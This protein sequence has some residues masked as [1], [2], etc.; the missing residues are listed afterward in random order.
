MWKMI[1]VCGFV[2]MIIGALVA[3]P[4]GGPL[5]AMQ[6]STTEAANQSLV[7]DVME[8]SAGSLHAANGHRGF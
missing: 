3:L 8:P 1:I 2:P 4:Y 7:F 6:N 5:P